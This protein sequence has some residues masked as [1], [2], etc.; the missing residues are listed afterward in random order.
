MTTTGTTH[1][2]AL[3]NGTIRTFDI[4]PEEVGLKRVSLDQ[5]KGG[6]AQHN[7]EAL[8][9]VLKGEGNPYRDIVLLNA[10]AALVVAGQAASISEGIGLAAKSID[11][12]AALSA[13]ES[14]VKT[15]NTHAP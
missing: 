13:L 5:L 10:G 12:G 1:I 8:M 14:L 9:R 6:D 2:A 4:T 11:D 15:S 7:A 3:E